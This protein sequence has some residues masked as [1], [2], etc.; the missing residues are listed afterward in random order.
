MPITLEKKPNN[1]LNWKER[2]KR[3]SAKMSEKAFTVND[4]KSFCKAVYRDRPDIK[5]MKTVFPTIRGE[6]RYH[7][8]TDR[9]CTN[10]KRLTKVNT[11]ILK[12]D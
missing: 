2:S 10:L 8:N 12:L 6:V 9:L 3:S 1:L 5:V 4:H 7:M 11:M